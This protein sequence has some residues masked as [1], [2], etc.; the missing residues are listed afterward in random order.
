[1]MIWV[2]GSFVSQRETVPGGAPPYRDNLIGRESSRLGWNQPAK[3]GHKALLVCLL[4]HCLHTWNVRL[5]EA[6]TALTSGWSSK[7]SKTQ[8]RTSSEQVNLTSPG[9]ATTH[10]RT[11]LETHHATTTSAANPQSKIAKSLLVTSSSWIYEMS[12][13]C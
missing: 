13:E 5:T 4:A 11:S 9:T 7:T 8:R 2:L 12:K 3:T 10:R 6:L 1:M